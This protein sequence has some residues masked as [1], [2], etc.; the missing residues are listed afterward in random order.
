[1]CMS[2][3][4][5]DS[6][7]HVLSAQIAALMRM[8]VVLDCKSPIYSTA[9]S[10]SLLYAIPCKACTAFTRNLSVTGAPNMD[11]VLLTVAETF[12]ISTK[13]LGRA[14]RSFPKSPRLSTPA[15]LRSLFLSSG[16]TCFSPPGLKIAGSSSPPLLPAIAVPKATAVWWSWTTKE[17][18]SWQ[19]CW[20]S[21]SGMVK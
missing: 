12:K 5:A 6:Q 9:P 21:L 13:D 2:F 7:D 3:T 4:V 15:L 17:H 1:M 8:R 18:Q 14:S 10:A 16:E 19:Y 11:A 20:R